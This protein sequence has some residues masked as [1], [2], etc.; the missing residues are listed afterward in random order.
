MNLFEFAKQYALTEAYQVDAVGAIAGP[1]GR[2]T[3]EGEEGEFI[4]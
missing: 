4:L 1:L 2:I 3:G